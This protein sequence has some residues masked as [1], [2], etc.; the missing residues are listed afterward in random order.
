[1]GLNFLLIPRYGIVVAAIVTVASELLILLGSYPLMRRYYGFFPAPR[2]LLGAVTAAAAMGGLLWLLDDA[3]LAVLVV[4]GAAVYG[5]LL[6]TLS[7]A[8]REL[9]SGLRT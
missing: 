7:P 6:W 2:T 8:S 1:V 9:L 5:G 4:L 3:P